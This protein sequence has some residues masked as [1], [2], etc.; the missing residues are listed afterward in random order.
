M[1]TLRGQV[2]KIYLIDRD[3][4]MELMRKL[5][6]EAA[7]GENRVLYFEARGGLGKTRLI[8]D[9]PKI[10]ERA[11]L[12]IL[13]ADIVDMYDFEN[14]KPI[15]IERKIVASLKVAALSQDISETEL[16]DIF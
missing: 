13:V 4:E 5:S 15:E 12:R 1:T 7:S 3:K 11:D 6:R 9:Y 8:Q 14:R 10:V 16:D 2:P